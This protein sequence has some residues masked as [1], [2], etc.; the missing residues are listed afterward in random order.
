MFE[1][2]IDVGARATELSECPSDPVFTPLL[3]AVLTRVFSTQK[4]I[5][6]W[7]PSV[8]R[9]DLPSDDK[10]QTHAGLDNIAITM[11]RREKHL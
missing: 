4:R 10:N 1:A 3:V 6:R 9:V 5:V 7:I 11:S 8:F 2:S